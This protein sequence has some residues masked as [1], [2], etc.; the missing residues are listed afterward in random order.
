MTVSRIYKL[1]TMQRMAYGLEIRI[2]GLKRRGA[3]AADIEIVQADLKRLQGEI[4]QL[5]AIERK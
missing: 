3:N 4:K 2:A 5:E 1:E